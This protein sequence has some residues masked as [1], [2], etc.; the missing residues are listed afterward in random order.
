MSGGQARPQR[1]PGPRTA[2]DSCVL[3]SPKQCQ[4]S[5]STHCPLL[6]S[7]ASRMS[8]RQLEQITAADMLQNEGLSGRSHGRAGMGV[9][10]PVLGRLKLR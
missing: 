5:P 6:G 2:Q 9:T 7:R 4:P 3:V 10:I 1:A 8:W